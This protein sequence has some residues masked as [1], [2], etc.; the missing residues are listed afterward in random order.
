MLINKAKQ[1]YPEFS[2]RVSVID[3]YSIP[4]NRFK[5]NVEDES[6]KGVLIIP[7]NDKLYQKKH[8]I[9]VNKCRVVPYQGEKQIRADKSCTIKY[10]E[11]LNKYA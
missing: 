3:F 7:K 10:S 5:V 9:I 11:E 8:K 2:I 1:H 6:G 4:D